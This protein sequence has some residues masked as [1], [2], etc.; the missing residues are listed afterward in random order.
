MQNHGSG[1]IRRVLVVEDDP[2]CRRHTSQGLRQGG[3]T[4][5]QTARI[6]EALK[7]ALSWRP[8]LIVTDLHLPDG[9]GCELARRVRAAWPASR[10]SPLLVAMTASGSEQDR[11]A[12]ADAG[13][14]R[15]IR[16][17][18]VPARLAELG[19]GVRGQVSDG[20]AHPREKAANEELHRLARHEVL[21]Q[22]PRLATLL[23]QG[24]LE[25]T[26]ALAHRLAAS[27]AVCGATDLGRRLQAFS[28]ACAD[29]PRT[30]EL[31]E[32]FTAA[33]RLAGDFVAGVAPRRESG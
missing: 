22:F 6:R 15:I 2:V 4:V 1:P 18:F 26:A 28:Q 30:A 8:D 31:A 5:K 12:M 27:A 14:D 21:R 19:D 9:T 20:E 29:R 25:K 33:R 23:E 13:F 17:P 10:P 16:K 3:S 7:L 24:R 11:A 32:R